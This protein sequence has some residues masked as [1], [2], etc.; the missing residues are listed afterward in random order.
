MGLEPATSELLVRDLTT[1]PPSHTRQLGFLVTIL[2]LAHSAENL[3]ESQHTGDDVYEM[4]LFYSLEAR[5]V[6]QDTT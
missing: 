6:Q 5:S 2:S 1:A 4:G 3:K